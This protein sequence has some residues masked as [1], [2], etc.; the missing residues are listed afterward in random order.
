MGNRRKLMMNK[1]STRDKLVQLVQREVLDDT[2]LERPILTGMVMVAEFVDTNGERMLFKL[3]SNRD[4]EALPHWTTL[5]FLHSAMG[6]VA[7]PPDEY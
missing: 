5:G 3:S 2:E 1:Q 7:E 6:M 4:G